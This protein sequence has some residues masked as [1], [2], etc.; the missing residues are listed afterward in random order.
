M[1]RSGNWVVAE[2]AETVDSIADCSEARVFMTGS[3]LV[4][5]LPGVT[6]TVV[7][8]N[9]YRRCCRVVKLSF[10]VATEARPE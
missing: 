10:T 9:L 1:T 5:R 8:N 3:E 4:L 6:G 7:V 2:P